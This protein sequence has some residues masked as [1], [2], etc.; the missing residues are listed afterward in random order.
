M[1]LC[2]SLSWTLNSPEWTKAAWQQMP[3]QGASSTN[4]S[5]IKLY[6]DAR[7]A[8]GKLVDLCNNQEVEVLRS[9]IFEQ[10]STAM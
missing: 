7:R 10:S 2:H 8:L 9:D 3:V 6:P 1:R 5:A 4:A